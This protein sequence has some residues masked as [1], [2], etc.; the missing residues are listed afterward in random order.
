M[1]ILGSG[2][3]DDFQKI[4]LGDKVVKALNVK[5]GDSILFYRGNG[6]QIQMQKAEGA[7]L[8]NEVEGDDFRPDRN[9]RIARLLLTIGIVVTVFILLISSSIFRIGESMEFDQDLVKLLVPSVV[10]IILMI[11]SNML[12]GRIANVGRPHEGIITVGGPFSRNR[13]IGVSKVS[14][15][16]HIVTTNAYC[17]PMFGVLPTSVQAEV[18]YRDGSTCVAPTMCT[19]DNPSLVV[20]RIRVPDGDLDTGSLKVTMKYTY[21]DKA[22]IAEAVYHL[23][24]VGRGNIKIESEEVTAHVDFGKDFQKET[25]DEALFD[26]LD[27]PAF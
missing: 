14:S 20:Y 19:R 15:D 23:S 2:K 7:Q 26:P 11:F 27:E 5:P 9:L 22:I 12:I 16:G 8:T 10:L 13:V 21:S 17:Y 1:K 3:I 18:E 25:F 24:V 6:R 4:V